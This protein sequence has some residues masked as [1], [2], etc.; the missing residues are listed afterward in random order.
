M[1]IKNLEQ[2]KYGAQK[3]IQNLVSYLIETKKIKARNKNKIKRVK[4]I[5]KG[6]PNKMNVRKDNLI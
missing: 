4:M 5:I 2:K 1:L 3:Y 6:M